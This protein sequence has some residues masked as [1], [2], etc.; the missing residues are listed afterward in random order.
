MF[1]FVVTIRVFG[2]VGI[3]PLNIFFSFL[4]LTLLSKDNVD[5]VQNSTKNKALALILAPTK[6]L[7]F[8]F[9]TCNCN[10]LLMELIVLGIGGEVEIV[11]RGGRGG[12]TS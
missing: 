4:S 11:G 3:E 5:C 2:L 12:K 6:L 9:K 10:V 8:C 1:V 7:I